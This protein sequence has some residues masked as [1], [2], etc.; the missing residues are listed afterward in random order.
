MV[1]ASNVTTCTTQKP[2]DRLSP[3]FC[4]RA[5]SGVLIVLAKAATQLYARL[6]SRV[7]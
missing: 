6:A 3:N 5:H 1:M 4:E 2:I 7:S